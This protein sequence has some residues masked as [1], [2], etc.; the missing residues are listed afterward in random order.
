MQAWMKDRKARLPWPPRVAHCAAGAQ[1]SRHSKNLARPTPPSSHVVPQCPLG[2][3][4][5][6][7]RHPSPADPAFPDLCSPRIQEGTGFVVKY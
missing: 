2:R 7:C 3:Q 5:W 6:P 1:G 4:M